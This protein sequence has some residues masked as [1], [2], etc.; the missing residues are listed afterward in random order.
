MPHGQTSE[1]LAYNVYD[2]L[3][4]LD[5]LPW[6]DRFKDLEA[7]GKKQEEEAKKNKPTDRV[8]GTQ[9][10]HNLADYAGDYQNP[11][12]GTIRV[13]LKG[14][15]LE[16][17]IN[18]LGPFPLEHYHYDIF[19]VPDEPDSVA[20]GEKVQFEMNKKGSI[21]RIAAALEPALGEDIIFTRAPEKISKE[22]LQGLTGEYLLGE[23]T[24]SL[25]LAGEALHL[26]VPGQPQYELVPT[27]GLSFDIK[28][29]PGFSV[30]FQK[31]ASGRIAEIVFNQPN[32]VFHAK[33]K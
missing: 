2:R 12:Y 31:D 24:V 7:K 16:F 11:G 27:K 1:L 10:S 30:D 3:L 13:A 20:S 29:L 14:G 15:A 22:V 4:G 32:G 5:Q 18:K 8:A 6:F 25:S 19:K 17:S 21:D 26:T 33:R 9:P 23:Q 28:G